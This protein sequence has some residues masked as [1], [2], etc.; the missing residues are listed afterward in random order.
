MK[1]P[2]VYSEIPQRERWKVREEYIRIQNG[3]C[4]YCKQPL[5]GKPSDEVSS[6]KINLWKF[7][8]NF[9][10]HPVH[11]HHSHE[12]DLTIGA[13]HAYCNAVLWEYHGE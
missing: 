11:L 4:Q 10:S 8:P 7:P 5:E 1:L 13:V 9:L 12:T 3:L 6:K 2:V